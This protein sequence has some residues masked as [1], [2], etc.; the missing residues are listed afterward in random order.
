MFAFCVDTTRDMCGISSNL[1]P[2]RDMTVV[3]LFDE[4]IIS[5]NQMRHEEEFPLPGN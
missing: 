1:F 3:A 2:E 4:Q 5:T